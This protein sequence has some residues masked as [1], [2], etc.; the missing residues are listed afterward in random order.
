MAHEE[1]MPRFRHVTAA[2]KADGGLLTEADIAAQQALMDWLPQLVPFPVLGEEM[3][4]DAQ[5]FLWAA[6][7]AGLWVVDP[8]DGTTNFARGLPCFSVSIALMRAGRP[9]LGVVYAPALGECFSAVAGHG[10]WCNG[11][12][13]RSG[14]DVP[15]AEAVAAIDIKRLSADLAVGVVR[16]RPYHAQR[17]FGASTLDWCWLAAGRMDVMLHCSQKLWD[18]AAGALILQEAG[19]QVATL[20]SEDFWVGKPW[21]RSV[22]AA[23]TPALF[24]EWREWVLAR[25][26]SAA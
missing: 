20:E 4:T 1:I 8:V 21:Q 24:A 10:A 26:P 15:L 7:Q 23:R 17:N 9:V 13:L 6:N 14:A 22:L 11:E 19:G 12:T 3:T 18:F 5:Q 16:N 25:R 2:I